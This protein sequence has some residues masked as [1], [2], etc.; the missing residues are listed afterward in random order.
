[1]GRHCAAARGREEDLEDRTRE[2]D[3]LNKITS[4]K[5]LYTI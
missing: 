3:Y 1:M 5:F 4:T 2:L